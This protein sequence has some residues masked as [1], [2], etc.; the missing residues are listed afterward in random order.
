[1][2]IFPP[3]NRAPEGPKET[4]AEPQSRRRGGKLSGCSHS[5]SPCPFRRRVSGSFH[6]V[7][8]LRR[9]QLQPAPGGHERKHRLLPRLA[10]YLQLEPVLK[11]RPEHEKHSVPAGT[12]TGRGVDLIA[13][14]HD[15][16]RTANHTERRHAIRIMRKIL[17]TRIGGETARKR[18]H[19]LDALTT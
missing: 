13:Q 17:Q 16:L 3:C 15:A 2:A 9:R 7:A 18:A 4:P 6:T 14:R 1:M 8:V 11:Q 10:V 5:P 12:S 19:V